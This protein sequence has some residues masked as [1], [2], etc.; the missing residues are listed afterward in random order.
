MNMTPP[1]PYPDALFTTAAI[2]A[3]FRLTLWSIGVSS[4]WIPKK[5]M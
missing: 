2:M 4:G 5:P 3:A 1:S